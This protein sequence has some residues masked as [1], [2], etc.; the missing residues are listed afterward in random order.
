MTITDLRCARTYNRGNDRGRYVQIDRNA[1]LRLEGTEA[2]T[3]PPGRSQQDQDSTF[4]NKR[5]LGRSHRQKPSLP[6]SLWQ[7][8]STAAS[9]W[10]PADDVVASSSLR[11]S[12][13]QTAP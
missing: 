2:S 12:D 8:T 5:L 4:R 7:H 1:E 10:H 13:A 6:K 9:T 3:P 11:E